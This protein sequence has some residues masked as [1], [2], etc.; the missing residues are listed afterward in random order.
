MDFMVM[1]VRLHVEHARV[2]LHMA[3]VS[4]NV[5]WVFTASSATNSVKRA[6]SITNANV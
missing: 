3:P 5:Q 2:I 1:I 4:V 6:V